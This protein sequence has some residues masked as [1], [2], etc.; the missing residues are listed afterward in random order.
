[1]TFKQIKIL[2]RVVMVIFTIVLYILFS[3]AIDLII[4]EINN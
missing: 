1:M 3:G 4:Y 2:K